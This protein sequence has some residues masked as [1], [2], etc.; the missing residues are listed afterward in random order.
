MDTVERNGKLDPVPDISSYG[1]VV[2]MVGPQNVRLRIQSQC[3]RCASKVFDAMF[4][5]H[6]IKGQGLSK[7]FP[8][9]VPLLEDD[10]DALRTI[11]CVIYHYNNDV[12]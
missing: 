9:E 3:L 5:P 8:Q 10:T 1:D 7:E 12:L 4:R 2:L 6:W 11:Y